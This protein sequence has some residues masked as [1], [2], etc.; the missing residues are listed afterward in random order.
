MI[1]YG[2]LSKSAV[3]PHGRQNLKE[4]EDFTSVA[5]VGLQ[6]F[7]NNHPQKFISRLA[8]GPPP[9]YRWLAWRFMSR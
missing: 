8:K 7:Y 1:Q 9:S 6:N 4:P 3:F 2:L 5:F